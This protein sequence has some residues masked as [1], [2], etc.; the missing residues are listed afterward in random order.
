MFGNMT[1]T[2][3]H[4]LLTGMKRRGGLGFLPSWLISS[5]TETQELGFWRT[6]PLEDLTV[7]DI[8]AFEGLLTM[9]FSVRCKDVFAF[10][11]HPRNLARLR[12]NLALNSIENVHVLPL[13]VGSTEGTVPLSMDSRMPGGA[14]ADSHIG[15]GLPETE[16]LS[17]VNVACITIDREI[18][19]GKLPPPDLMK[20]DV[21]GLE[22]SVLIGAQR[23]LSQYSPVLYIEMHGETRQ[24]KIDNARLV[25]EQL[26]QAGYDHLQHLETGLRVG[27]SDA[28]TA[29]EGHLVCTKSS[30]HPLVTIP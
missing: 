4:G 10:E 28:L 23:T 24:L 8:G 26:R 21:E 17:V 6:Y 25:L 18:S 27:F 9:Y 30:L 3:R 7:Y 20:I 5:M 1:Y 2:V 19:T 29:A 16:S 12:E 11:P 14:S 15:R 13:A 22:A